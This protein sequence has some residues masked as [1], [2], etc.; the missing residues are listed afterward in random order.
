MKNSSLLVFILFALAA[1]SCSGKKSGDA[2]AGAVAGDSSALAEG[3][4]HAVAALG[5]AKWS[6]TIDGALV[7]GTGVDELQ[8]NNAAYVLPVS[9]AGPKHLVFHLFSTKNGTDESANFSLRFS[10]PPKAGTYTKHGQTEHSC[11]CDLTLN[12]NIAKGGALAQYWADSVVITVTEMSPTRVKGTFAGSFVVSSDT[13]RAPNKR[14]KI[15]E[16]TFDIPMATSK[17]TPE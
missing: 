5:E 17:M 2:A 12:E 15:A 13:P 6:A 8:Q 1:T 4:S 7:T 9:G 10:L 11:D 14:A 3:S 16:G